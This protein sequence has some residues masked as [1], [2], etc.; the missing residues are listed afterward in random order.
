[1]IAKA[2]QFYQ[3]KIQPHIKQFKKRGARWFL[4]NPLR[5]KGRFSLLRTKLT[6]F[7]LDTIEPKIETLT[8]K[9]AWLKRRVTGLVTAARAK[10]AQFK[11]RLT[12][13]LAR[14]KRSLGVAIPALVILALSVVL[15]YLW[16]QSPTFR[17]TLKTM[18]V[19]G[20]GFLITLWALLKGLGLGLNEGLKA[21][22]LRF[23]GP[24]VRIVVVAAADPAQADVPAPSPDG[25][26]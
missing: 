21:L 10:L 26:L 23:T 4:W 16:Q 3:D 12:G 8:T 1:M 15:L 25:R 24:V 18:G 20:L 6:G 9:M 7:Y 5:K 14:H 11:Q 2:T 19:A 17:T 22:W 13:W